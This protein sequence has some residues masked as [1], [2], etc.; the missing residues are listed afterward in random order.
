[1]HRV[2][3]VGASLTLAVCA[4]PTLGEQ[5]ITTAA[6]HVE[7][8]P[9]QGTLTVPSLEAAVERVERAP[10][11]VGVVDAETVREGRAATLDDALRLAPGVLA[12]PRF[13]AEEARLSIRGSGIQRTF[14]LR[15]IKLLQ[16]GVPLNLADG[17]G[18]F[19]AVEPL[20]TQYIEVYRGANALQYGATTL[21]GAI[22]FV[23]PTGYAAPGLT[24]RAEGGSFGYVRGQIALAG[25]RGPTDYYVSGTLSSQDGFR[26][27]SAQSNGRL[28]ANLGQRLGGGA[29]TRF[30]VTLTD[31]DSQL[32]GNLFK[33][34]LETDPELANPVNLAGRYKR[35]FQLAR[36]ANKTTVLLGEH[37][38]IEASVFYSWKDLFHPIFQVLDVVSSDYGAEVRYLSEAPLFGLK[39]YL[40]AGFAP[41]RGVADDVR[42][43][44]LG[45]R[46]GAMTASSYQTAANLDFYAEE[47]L[48][49]LPKLAAVLGAQWTRASRRLEDR[50]LSNGDN[51]FD[52]VYRGF[53]P[54][55]G[56]RYELT[57]TVQV[58]G[59][60]SESFEPPTFGEL[61]GGPG[62]TPVQAQEATTWEI[63]TRG[64]LERLTWDVAWY[65]A[66]VSG[67]LLSLL[68]PTGQPLGTVNA[69]KTLHQ[70]L[71]LGA[72]AR[73][74]GRLDLRVSYL[75]N[76]FRFVDDPVFGDNRLP[77][78]PRHFLNAD[79][80]YRGEEGFYAG[81][82]VTWSPASY[83]VDMANTLFADPYVLF[84]LRAGRRAA[85]GWSWF[86]E[87]RNLTDERYAASTGVIATAG[88]RDSQQFLP[89]DGR[90]FYAGFEWRM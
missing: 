65:R 18:D 17:S 14:H 19:Q 54:K 2:A 87:V 68:S 46:R 50:F 39:S 77:G 90:A 45:G 72:G 5:A 69:D 67:E 41:A 59:N 8:T 33:S 30:Y 70:G 81:P 86:V 79:L 51:S 66:R 64:T 10:G 32:P 75:F 11:G 40:T 83:P 22:N 52:Q 63:G 27:W 21:G 36:V 48:Y 80:M 43:Q 38:R 23:S 49:V 15:G 53:S 28:F 76:D 55:G 16:D 24:V 12:Q 47:Q 89:G 25:V 56:F 71:E 4:G 62:I 34:E 73:L 61:A 9:A 85:Q 7:A 82:T 84:G 57:P 13:G 6:T 42:W 3:A 26:D 44:N 31:S 37:S 78:I 58:F 1:M 60:I 20:A 29:E 88:G 35:D 74:P